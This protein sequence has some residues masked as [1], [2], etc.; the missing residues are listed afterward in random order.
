MKNI[1]SNAYKEAYVDGY[2]TGLNPLKQ[3]KR[4]RN[5][6]AFVVGFNSGRSDY[7]RM[8]GCI[9]NGIPQRIITDE[10]LEDYLLAGLL[11]LPIEIYGYSSHQINLIDQW[12]QSGIEMYDP[13]QN[14]HLSEILEK[15]GITI[16]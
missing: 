11:G 16:R 8:N 5:N 10:L 14:T 6:E 12:Y 15:N 3:F 4:L 9:S 13:D 1:F 2:S 7:E